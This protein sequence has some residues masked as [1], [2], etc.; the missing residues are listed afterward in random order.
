M[1]LLVVQVVPETTQISKHSQ[2]IYAQFYPFCIYV[3]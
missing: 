2:K 1:K 3:E